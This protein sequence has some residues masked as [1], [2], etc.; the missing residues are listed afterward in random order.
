MTIIE[1][2]NLVT[3]KSQKIAAILKYFDLSQEEF[4]NC[5]CVSHTSV[6]RWLKTATQPVGLHL[7][8]IEALYTVTLEANIDR[9]KATQQLKLG[10][11]ALICYGLI[12]K[13]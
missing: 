2:T 4:E 8:V 12:R 6:E 9:Q 10:I 11:G 7:T 13:F 3:S 1:N 5:L